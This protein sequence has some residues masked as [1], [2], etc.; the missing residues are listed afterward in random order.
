MT[1]PNDTRKQK[2][3]LP[4]YITSGTISPKTRQRIVD[5]VVSQGFPEAVLSSSV[6]KDLGMDPGWANRALYHSGFRPGKAKSRK[7]GRP[8]YTPD[9]ILCLKAD[10]AVEEELAQIV[11]EVEPIVPAMTEDVVTEETEPT[12]EEESAVLESLASPI[13]DFVEVE[14]PPG[15]M[16]DTGDEPVQWADEVPKV[17]TVATEAIAEDLQYIDTRDSWVPDMNELLGGPL[18][19]MVKERLQV[20]KAVGIDFE[21]RVWRTTK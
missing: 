9:D 12:P 15:A 10:P 16:G 4:A 21:I 3:E 8:W 7:V 13:E 19:V 1:H 11:D 6:V 5:Y 2:D 20:L 18:Y 17:I 14:G